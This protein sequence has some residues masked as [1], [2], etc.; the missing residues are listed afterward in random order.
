MPKLLLLDLSLRHLTGSSEV[1]TVLSRLGHCASYSRLLELET[2]ACK[3]LDEM[4]ITVPGTIDLSRN[5]VT[6]ICWDTF[7]LNEEIPSRAGTTHTSNG[8]IIREISDPDSEVRNVFPEFEA[9][10]E[11]TKVVLLKFSILFSLKI[12][13]SPRH[14]SLSQPLN[15]Q[16]PKSVRSRAIRCGFSPENYFRKKRDNLFPNGLPGNLKQAEK[17]ISTIMC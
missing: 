9:E 12:K 10:V 7:D 8:I 3:A 1:V 5:V 14:L 2:A 13:Q 11:K 15:V 6:H 17:I 4:K 16:T